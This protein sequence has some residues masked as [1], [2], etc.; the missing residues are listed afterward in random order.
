VFLSSFKWDMLGM[1][2]ERFW[3]KKTNKNERRLVFGIAGIGA[4]DWPEIRETGEKGRGC[5]GEMGYVF[6]DFAFWSLKLF[7]LSVCELIFI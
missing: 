5:L 2:G 1:G 6:P 4:G 7:N 3:L